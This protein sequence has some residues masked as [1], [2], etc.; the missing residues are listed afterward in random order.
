MSLTILKMS[1]LFFVVNKEHERCSN[2]LHSV[3]SETFNFL[4]KWFFKRHYSFN[5]WKQ[6]LT[7]LFKISL[8]NICKFYKFGHKFWQDELSKSLS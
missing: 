3:K 7:Y 5:A 6:V 8:E 1:P 4:K 2:S